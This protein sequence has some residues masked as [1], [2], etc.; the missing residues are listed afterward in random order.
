MAA[1][2]EGRYRLEFHRSATVDRAVI[3]CEA[4][5]FSHWY[6]NTEAELSE[7]YGPYRD[8]TSFLVVRE[9]DGDV[10][11]ISRLIRPGR[12]PLKTFVDLAAAP[13]N[14]DATRSAA[15]AG[16]DPARAWDV[17]TIAVRPELGSSG[18]IIGLALF[19]GLSR[20]GEVNRI[21]WMTAILDRRVRALM[22]V[23]GLDVH[24]LP[25][26]GPAAYLGS[27][28]STP[29]FARLPALLAR[30]RGVNVEAHRMLALGEGLDD[31][32]LPRRE[33]Y[34][35]PGS[36]LSAQ[37]VELENPVDRLIDVRREGQ[38]WLGRP[39]I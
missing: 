4:E 16:I 29:V 24:T 23:L 35:M 26:A 2:P 6:G 28:A 17:A 30:Q 33:D 13:W 11:G 19:H 32:V 7:V 36:D 8:Q 3:R 14:V 38:E 5:V 20:V 9:R 15:A 31:V 39:G 34:R 37:L 27:E 12:L 18:R 10:V 22:A 25:G 21:E 1:G